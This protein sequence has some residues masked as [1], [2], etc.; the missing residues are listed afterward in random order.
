MEFAV[1]TLSPHPFCKAFIPLSK[2]FK[3]P[4]YE[5]KI[6]DH[7]IN[8]V[9]GLLMTAKISS[10]DVCMKFAIDNSSKNIILDVDI[11]IKELCLEDI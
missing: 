8:Q 11:V 6:K 4:G 3:C 2:L 10:D 9:E 1:D 7:R 5:Y